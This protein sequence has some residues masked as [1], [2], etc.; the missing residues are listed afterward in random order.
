MLAGNSSYYTG[1]PGNKSM[2]MFSLKQCQQ[3]L[4]SL[5]MNKKN[6]SHRD[7]Q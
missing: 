6:H 3:K 4:V 1:K 5:T 2:K 7:D